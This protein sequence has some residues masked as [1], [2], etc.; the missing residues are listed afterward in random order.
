MYYIHMPVRKSLL[1]VQKHT[2]FRLLLFTCLHPNYI[3]E[4]LAQAPD[5]EQLTKRMINANNA[6]FIG[7]G[8]D[9][10][11]CMEGALKLKEISYIHAEAYAAGE[12]KH[13]TIAL[14]SEGVPVIAAATQKHVYSKVISNIREVKARGAYVILCPKTKKSQILLSVMYTSIFRMYP[15]NLRFLNLL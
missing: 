15:T 2:P 8:L 11:L 14:V 5:I 3:E 10:T 7:R 1:Q 9:Y 6:F 12:L 4:V 13:G